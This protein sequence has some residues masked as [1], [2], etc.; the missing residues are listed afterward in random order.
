MKEIQ[1]QIGADAHRRDHFT[2][3]F[4]RAHLRGA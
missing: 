3:T 4:V 1:R 2:R